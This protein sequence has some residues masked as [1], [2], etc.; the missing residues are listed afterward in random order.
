[1]TGDYIFTTAPP[2]AISL[3]ITSPLAGETVLGQEIR[4]QGT[5]VNRRGLETGVTVNGASATISGESYFANNIVL[6]D[7]ENIL[8]VK[9]VDAE[10]NTA[11]ESVSVDAIVSSPCVR[12]MANI[13]SGVSTLEVYLRLDGTF[14][15]EDSSM[16]VSGP[17]PVELLS[18]TVDEYVVRMTDEGIYYFTAEAADDE[19][20]LHDDTVAVI[21]LNREQLDALLKSKWEGMKEALMAQDIPSAT[22]DIL[23]ESQSLYNAI[24]SALI[25]QLPQ[26]I[27]G[28]QDIQLIYAQGGTAK[29]RLRKNEF[30]GTGM[31]MLT[32]YIY[33]VIDRDG[34][35]K[36]YRY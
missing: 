7:G 18:A 34:L 29:Y 27:Q 9:A 30:Y 21:V 24:Y 1:M 35:W 26:L 11:E 28:M 25:D 15:F 12:L 23:R 31:E 13:E 19:G 2:P 6:G 10:G 20:T 16:T 33:F 17:G 22:H 8:T 5:V 32:Y 14:S 4:V 3:T 36:I